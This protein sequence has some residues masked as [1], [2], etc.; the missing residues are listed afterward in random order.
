MKQ[1]VFLIADDEEDIC[2]FIVEVASDLGFS[3]SQVNNG[4]D[5]AAVY[6]KIDPDV[7]FLDLKLP[8]KD[9]IELLEYLGEARSKANVVMMSGMDSQTLA[10]AKKLADFHNVNL[11]KT[12]QKPVVLD[13]LEEIISELI[14]PKDEPTITRE[15]ICLGI[16]KNEFC[17]FYQPKFLVSSDAPHVLKGA[18][19]L[20]RWEHPQLGWISPDVFIIIAERTGCIG[21]LTNYIF[22]RVV[23][24]MCEWKTQGIEIPISV[25]ISQC[26]FQTTELADQFE[27][28]ALSNDILP[29][30]IILEVTETSIMVDPNRSL[31][32]LTRARLKGFR[33]SLDDFGVGYSS[34]THLYRMPFNELKVDR[35]FVADA[36][37]DKGAMEI[38][39]F[40]ISLGESL[41]LDVCLEG[42]ENIETLDLFVRERALLIQGYHFSKPLPKNQFIAF[43]KKFTTANAKPTLITTE[44]DKV[45]ELAEAK[46]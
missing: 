2:D 39:R 41:N 30:N 25:N 33:L 29:S 7:I 16:E 19:A 37:H 20:A 42:V 21:E 22:N 14:P 40:L 17:V 11:T 1:P 10:S 9:G 23:R 4:D 24:D 27:K 5:F 15:D 36:L 12:I 26:L 28:I 46:L 43:A 32:V 38:V 31:A 13:E 44:P 35:L 45:P 18:E 34:L 8:G 6:S 3:C